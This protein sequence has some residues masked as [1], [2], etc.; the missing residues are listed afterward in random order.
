VLVVTHLHQIA[1]LADQH[2]C[3]R[4]QAQAGRTATGVQRLQGEA[5]LKEMARM[6][7]GEAS[8]KMVIEHARE[9]LARN[10]VAS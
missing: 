4:K 3:I 1:S 2:F 5:R 8:G 9:L 7:G 10:R 6:L